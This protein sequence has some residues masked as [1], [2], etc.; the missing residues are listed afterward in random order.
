MTWVTTPKRTSRVQRVMY[1]SGSIVRTRVGISQGDQQVVDSEQGHV[2]VHLLP[3]EALRHPWQGA[4][5]EVQLLDDRRDD[6]GSKQEQCRVDGMAP[7]PCWP[8]VPSRM[9]DASGHHANA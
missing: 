8:S 1:A 4:T 7:C 2:C 3:S 9:A 5:A 6:Q